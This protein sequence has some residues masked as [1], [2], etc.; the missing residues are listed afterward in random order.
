M[1]G[2]T[3]NDTQYCTECKNKKADRRKKPD[4]KGHLQSHPKNPG[5]TGF[6]AVSYHSIKMENRCI[7]NLVQFPYAGGHFFPGA[8]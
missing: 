7:S 2:R 5:S 8:Q 6:P 1:Q 4:V 3:G